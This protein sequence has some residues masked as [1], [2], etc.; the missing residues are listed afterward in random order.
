MKKKIFVNK[1][2]QSRIPVLP[3]I[4]ALG[5]HWSDRPG[6]FYP[7][8]VTSEIRQGGLKKACFR[9]RGGGEGDSQVFAARC[10]EYYER[11]R[12]EAA[13]RRR[14]LTPSRR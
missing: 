5:G 4:F 6:S 7:S 8:H 12:E 14:R 11:V 3:E 9:E 2:S 1:D 10:R 13:R